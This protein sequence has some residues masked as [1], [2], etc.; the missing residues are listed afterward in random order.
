[1]VKLQ[2]HKGVASDCPENTIASFECAAFQGYDVIE[3][4]LDYT[5][6]KKIVVLHDSTINNT[7]RNAD[8][9]KIESE[10]R[11]SDITYERAFEFDFGIWF[12][13]DFRGER[14]PLFKQVL[15]LVF[16]SGIKLKIDNKIMAFPED[17]LDIF[18][19]EIRGYEEF[20]S[21]TSNEL[22][23]VKKC[24]NR[25]AKLSIDYDGLI[26]ESILMALIELLPCDRLTVWLPYKSEATSWVTIPFADTEAVELIKRYARL[27]LWII[28]DCKTFAS[29]VGEFSP[30]IV[31]T[32]GTVKPL[33]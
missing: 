31:E 8:G 6:D 7:A 26:D 15:Q 13:E 12:S 3:L 33:R 5:L 19:E 22:D 2:A 1:M 25:N 10:I 30:Y 32:D 21:V 11:I 24:L 16:K 18:F 14:L 29:A 17:V 27:G 28:N 20:V 23:F 9:S 4:D